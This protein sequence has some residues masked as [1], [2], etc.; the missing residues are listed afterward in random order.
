MQRTRGVSLKD[1]SAGFMIMAIAVAMLVAWTMGTWWMFFP[2]IFILA[3]GFYAALGFVARIT[4]EPGRR[5]PSG[6][7]YYVFWGPTLVILGIM[8]LLISETDISGV[9]L[10]VILLLWVGGIAIA[11][12]LGGKRAVPKA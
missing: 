9:L 4:D 10:L 1:I 3:G 8:W 12:S 7:S 5:G 6:S 2:V 11:L